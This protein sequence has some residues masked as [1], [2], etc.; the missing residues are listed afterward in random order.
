MSRIRAKDTAPELSVRK[1]AHKLGLRFRLHRKDL[2]GC[3]DMVF[4]KHLVV[5]FVHGCFWHQHKNCK[6]A[7]MP[8]SR[9]S[10]WRKKLG[11]NVTRD[12]KHAKALRAM[13]WRVVTVWECQTKDPKNLAALI[14]RKFD[15]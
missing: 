7:K 10:Y 13:G 5:L 14:T 12:R 15:L 11:G 4:K 6:I 9:Q 8:K 1:Q 3:P 2:P